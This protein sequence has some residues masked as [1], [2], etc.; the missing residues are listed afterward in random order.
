MILEIDSANTPSSPSLEIFDFRFLILDVEILHVVWLL[1]LFSK[2]TGF[3]VTRSHLLFTQLAGQGGDY[4]LFYMV[5]NTDVVPRVGN[6]IANNYVF[7]RVGHQI[8]A[9]V[10]YHD[11]CQMET[12][13][14]TDSTPD[15]FPEY[16]CPT[17]HPLEW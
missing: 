3:G 17:Q 7:Y 2:Q 11:R 10:E 16:R 4:D 6:W 12:W 15:M 9:P 8:A 5:F 1:C 14:K 13:A